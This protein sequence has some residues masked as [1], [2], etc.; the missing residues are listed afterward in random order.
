MALTEIVALLRTKSKIIYPVTQLK[1]ITDDSEDLTA[2][3]DAD[4]VPLVDASDSGQMKKITWARIKTALSS[5]FAAKS[6]T[7]EN[8]EYI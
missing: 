5:V 2:P 6:H 7:H 4:S 3:A 1:N 8:Y